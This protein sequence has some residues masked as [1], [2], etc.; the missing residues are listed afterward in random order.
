MFVLPI[1]FFF[2]LLEL[3]AG[4]CNKCTEYFAFQ[5]KERKQAPPCF[6]LASHLNRFTEKDK[7]V[8]LEGYNAIS[9]WHLF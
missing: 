2:F 5:E 3:F 1:K 4:E 9:L 6:V 8:H 7:A